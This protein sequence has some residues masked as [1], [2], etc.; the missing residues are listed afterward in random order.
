MKGSP[1]N[2]PKELPPQLRGLSENR[3][4]TEL[5]DIIWNQLGV[6]V[7]PNTSEA[8]ALGLLW[9]NIQASELEPNPVNPLRDEL[10]EFIKQNIDLLSLPCDGNCYGH[11]DAKVLQCHQEFKRDTAAE[12]LDLNISGGLM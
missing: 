8:D 12:A 9:Y 2:P 4:K 5:V 3:L 1:K 10:I 7:H 11:S 6:R